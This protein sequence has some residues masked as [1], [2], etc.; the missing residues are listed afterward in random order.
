M[1]DELPYAEPAELMGDNPE[2]HV[3][4]ND[5][6]GD[7]Y[8]AMPGDTPFDTVMS[9]D[10]DDAQSDGACDGYLAVGVDGIDMNNASS[11][12]E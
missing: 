11:D 7:A 5:R 12:D 8:L 1:D 10:D 9:N 4:S 2:D 6:D 3:D